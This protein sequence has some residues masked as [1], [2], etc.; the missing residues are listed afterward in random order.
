[1]FGERIL[2][3]KLLVKYRFFIDSARPVYDLI[4]HLLIGTPKGLNLRNL[5]WHGFA[6]PEEMDPVFPAALIILIFSV[7]PLMPRETSQ[8]RTLTSLSQIDKMRNT[9]DTENLSEV[10]MFCNSVFK[11][12]KFI[13]SQIKSNFTPFQ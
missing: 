10:S 1:L 8:S 5:A 4:F 12:Y 9:F 2:A 13:H 3:Q 11:D 7:S 6:S